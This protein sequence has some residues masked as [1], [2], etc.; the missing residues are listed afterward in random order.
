MTKK[1]K[2]ELKSAAAAVLD[3]RGREILDSTPMAPPVGYK[4][5]Q[6]M[7]DIIRQTIRSER[8]AA[9]ARAA[10][11]ETFEEADDFDILDDPVDPNTPFEEMFDPPPYVPPPRTAQEEL[12]AERPH[13]RAREDFKRAPPASRQQAAPAAK[14]AAPA[15]SAAPPSP[16]PRPGSEPGSERS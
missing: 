15:A 14:E 13:A 2:P 9:E 7:T 1:L 5:P 4:P 6:H 16:P 11:M 12:Q 10:E 3:G 8:L